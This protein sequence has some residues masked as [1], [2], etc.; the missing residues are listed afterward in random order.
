MIEDRRG[1]KEWPAAPFRAFDPVTNAFDG[2]IAVARQS[3][4]DN[5]K[6]CPPIDEKLVAP[7]IST[8]VA[9]A[10]T[11]THAHTAGAGATYRSVAVG[12]AYAHAGDDEL[13]DKV[14]QSVH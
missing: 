3:I 9:C 6:I 10:R 7:G 1:R 5:I 2:E 8:S 14:V 4:R 12:L 13:R 11:R